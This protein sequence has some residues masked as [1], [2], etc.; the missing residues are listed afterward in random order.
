MVG[1]SAL[2]NLFLMA[3]LVLAALG[4]E[5]RFYLSDGEWQALKWLREEVGHDQVVLC[6]PQTGMFVPAWAGQRVVYGHPFET[7]DAEER[8]AQAQAYWTGRMSPA[9]QQAFLREN[10]VRYVLVGP[11]EL[12]IGDWRLEIGVLERSPA[13]EAGDVKVYSVDGP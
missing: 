9:E 5:P 12:A 6:A 2:T 1:S 13:F 4:G 11:R 8:R 10:R 7:V 3:M